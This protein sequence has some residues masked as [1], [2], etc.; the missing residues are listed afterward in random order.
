MRINQPCVIVPIDDLRFMEETG[1][2]VIQCE[3]GAP[4]F[5]LRKYFDRKLVCYRIRRTIGPVGG[6]QEMRLTWSIGLRDHCWTHEGFPP[7]PREWASKTHPVECDGDGDSPKTM[8]QVVER[9]RKHGFGLLDVRF[10]D[11][12]GPIF[13][14]SL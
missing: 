11:D 5:A 8:R 1:A 7:R 4:D 3:P 13:E 6:D 9:A 14:A 12:R 10:F 2:R